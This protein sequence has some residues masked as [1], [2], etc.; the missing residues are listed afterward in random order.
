M[1]VDNQIVVDAKAFAIR[2]IKL[3]KYLLE[4]KKE[5]VMANRC[6]AAVRALGRILVKAFSHKADWIL[7]AK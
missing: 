1:K 2:I 5:Y 3:Y 4:E 7:S 6:Y